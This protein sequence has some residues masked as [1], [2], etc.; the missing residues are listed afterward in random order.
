MGLAEDGRAWSYASRGCSAGDQGADGAPGFGGLGLGGGG[1]CRVLVP[2]RE[3][4]RRRRFRC[5]VI[6][7]QRRQLGLELRKPRC[8]RRRH[9]GRPRRS[10]VLSANAADLSLASGSP[11]TVSAG[12]RPVSE[13]GLR[14]RGS[15]VLSVRHDVSGDHRHRHDLDAGLRGA[16]LLGRLGCDD[17]HLRAARHAVV[18]HRNQQ[19]IRRRLRRIHGGSVESRLRASD[20]RRGNR[21]RSVLLVRGRL[22][23]VVR[24]RP[25]R[26]RCQPRANRMLLARGRVL[27]GRMKR[28]GEHC[29]GLAR[30]IQ[31][32]VKPSTIAATASER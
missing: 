11:R 9:R 29:G 31:S 22:L 18:R 28:Q 12:N 4:R 16:C 5:I 23:P 20:Q 7:Q 8:Q 19:R 17:V 3:R 10:A 26:P 2:G 27:F 24:S 25:L 14:R 6:I 21:A 30:P 1:R 32:C 15:A 13:A